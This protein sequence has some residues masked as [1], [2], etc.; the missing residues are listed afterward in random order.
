MTILSLR[1]VKIWFNETG[2]HKY[3]FAASIRPLRDIRTELADI[4][5]TLLCH[6][7][8]Q[9]YLSTPTIWKFG[10]LIFLRN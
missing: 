3:G 8:P 1:A 5:G 2:I 6:E 10:K 7:N 4:G 9:T